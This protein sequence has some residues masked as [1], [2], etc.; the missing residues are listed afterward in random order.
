MTG[1][2]VVI[3]SYGAQFLESKAKPI[4]PFSLFLYDLWI[5]EGYLHL[6]NGIRLM[7]SR[8]VARPLHRR[9][10]WWR[11][12]KC[13]WRACGYYHDS[14]STTKGTTDARSLSA[15]TASYIRAK[16]ASETGSALD[17]S[18]P[19]PTNRNF[20]RQLRTKNPRARSDHYRT[21][22]LKE[23]SC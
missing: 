1:T 16:Y 20:Y 2:P 17:H 15:I 18:F 23:E 21:V 6:R 13:V 11:C 5:S 4:C 19:C 8:S 7:C 14:E 9:F 22:T 3:A 10:F 12:C